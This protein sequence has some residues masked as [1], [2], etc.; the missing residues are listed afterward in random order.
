MKTRDLLALLAT[1]LAAALLTGTPAARADDVIKTVYHLADDR[2]ATLAMNNI[3]NHLTA[4]P[5]VKIVVVALATGVR[6][7]TFG[8]QDGSGRPF[9]E[10]V[11]QLA[12]RGVQFRICENSMNAM[13]LSKSDLID[14][15]EIVA[16]GV[17][18]IA[19]LEARE[20]YVYIRP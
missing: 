14:K 2:Q 8:A 7:F 20:G 4:D 15:V 10:W 17:A 19:R 1:V 13:R 3:S 16:S 12:A 18:E 11:D 9:S 6:V 5:G